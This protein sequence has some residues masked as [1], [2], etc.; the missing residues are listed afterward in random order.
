MAN[1]GV[2]VAKHLYLQERL[3]SKNFNFTYLQSTS[4]KKETKIIFMRGLL[5][6]EKYVL[7]R[8]QCFGQR[9]LTFLIHRSLKLTIVSQ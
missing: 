1:G 8:N 3:Y 9:T 5:S 6:W 4:Q 2:I 7:L